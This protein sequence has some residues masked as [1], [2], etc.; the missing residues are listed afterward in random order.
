MPDGGKVLLDAE[1]EA[2]LCERTLAAVKPPRDAG[3]PAIASAR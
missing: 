2:S 1:L 3:K